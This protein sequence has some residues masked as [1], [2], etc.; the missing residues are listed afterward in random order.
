MTKWILPVNAKKINIE[1][2]LFSSSNFKMKR[3][4]TPLNKSAKDFSSNNFLMGKTNINSISLN[5][6]IKLNKPKIKPPQKSNR[7]FQN[8]KLGIGFN[9]FNNFNNKS[10]NKSYNLNKVNRTVTPKDKFNL[11]KSSNFIGLKSLKL[12]RS[13]TP[14]PKSKTKFGLSKSNSKPNFGSNIN[15]NYTFL[16]LVFILLKKEF[17]I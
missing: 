13:T 7:F 9:N 12:N 15:I 1:G 16:F 6:S 4:K 8:V 10:L 5:N 11:S 17:I 14:N 3:A 2:D